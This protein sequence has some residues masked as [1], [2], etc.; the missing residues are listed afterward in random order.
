MIELISTY[1]R[2]FARFIQPQ[3]SCLPIS[4]ATVF[5]HLSFHSPS[6]HTPAVFI[7]YLM[8]KIEIH[9]PLLCRSPRVSPFALLVDTYLH[10][11]PDR[12]LCIMWNLLAYDNIVCVRSLSNGVCSRTEHTKPLFHFACLSLN[13]ILLLS[14]CRLYGDWHWKTVRV[15]WYDAKGSHS[16]AFEN[17][18]QYL[19]DSVYV[20]V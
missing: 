8:H 7:F 6:H 20:R 19:C 2:F 4:L 9:S 17:I 1:P 14:S 16:F 15:K 10:T 13:L 3:A 12:T 18:M 5:L 11:K